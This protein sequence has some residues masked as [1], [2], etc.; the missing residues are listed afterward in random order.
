MCELHLEVGTRKLN[1]MYD[2]G[3]VSVEK[4]AFIRLFLVCMIFRKWKLKFSSNIFFA[5]P[6]RKTVFGPSQFVCIYT[7]LSPLAQVNRWRVHGYFVKR[8]YSMPVTPVNNSSASYWNKWMKKQKVRR[9]YEFQKRAY[10]RVDLK[11]SELFVLN[12]W[13]TFDFAENFFL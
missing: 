12:Y 10:W 2:P 7:F 6:L 11:L 9:K 8:K 5:H 4:D 3:P 13:I 1:W